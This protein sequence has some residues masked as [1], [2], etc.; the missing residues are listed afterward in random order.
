MGNYFGYDILLTIRLQPGY[1]AAANTPADQYNVLQAIQYRQATLNGD[2]G[3][4]T[5]AV[6][7]CWLFHLVGDIHQ[8]TRSTALFNVARFPEGDRGG[9]E[10]PVTKG[11][12]LHSL[13]DNLLGRQ[14]YMKDVAKAVAELTDR[15]R[16]GDVRDS[17][18]KELNP[19]KWAE[20]SHKMCEEVVYS[21]AILKAVEGRPKGQ[22]LVPIE[23]TDDYLKQAGQL[24]RERV[25][26]AGVRLGVLLGGRPGTVVKKGR[27]R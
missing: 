5:K 27:V 6:A 26:A 24:A 19:V 10:I 9:N 15:G 7:Y 17:A 8:P 21:K 12:N 22:E 13:W 3:P 25:L 20:E 18:A 23:L 16:S 1:R 11:K 14:Y 2:T 4:E